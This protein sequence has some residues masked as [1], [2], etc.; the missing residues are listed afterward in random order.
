M[1][2]VKRHAVVKCQ[3]ENRA[4]HFS[5]KHHRFFFIFNTQPFECTYYFPA[6]YMDFEFSHYI[7]THLQCLCN[8]A[9]ELAIGDWIFQDEPLLEPERPQGCVYKLF[10]RLK[11]S[12]TAWEA[13]FPFSRPLFSSLLPFFNNRSFSTPTSRPPNTQWIKLVQ[14]AALKPTPRLLPGSHTHRIVC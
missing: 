5:T 2:H 1:K 10:P 7:H 6:Y 12:N 13:E 9:V 14:H 11:L 3:K 4:F 8:I